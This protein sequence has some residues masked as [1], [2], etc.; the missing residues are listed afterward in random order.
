MEAMQQCAALVKRAQHTKLIPASLL[1]NRAL[2]AN[3]LYPKNCQFPHCVFKYCTKG[4]D[5]KKRRLTT[6]PLVQDNQ[7]LTF[8]VAFKKQ[9]AARD[10]DERIAQQK[11][12]LAIFT[13]SFILH[14]GGFS[15]SFPGSSRF[16]SHSPHESTCKCTSC[17]NRE[18]GAKNFNLPSAR[19]PFKVLYYHQ[20]NNL[21]T[22]YSICP[23]SI[24]FCS[25]MRRMSGFEVAIAHAAFPAS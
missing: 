10:T 9:L 25:R 3:R 16:Q 13:L 2:R 11:V 14:T 7:H 6:G 12:H 8:G 1:G 17:F 23:S 24:S 22:L 18:G 15:V 20:T 5:L 19:S 4:H 21:P